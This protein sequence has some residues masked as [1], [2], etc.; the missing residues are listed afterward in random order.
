M[1]RTAKPYYPEHS[2]IIN[3]YLSSVVI[4]YREVRLCLQCKFISAVEVG[5]NEVH[6]VTLMMFFQNAH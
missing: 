4:C 2:E 3:I 6:I 1:Q 5:A